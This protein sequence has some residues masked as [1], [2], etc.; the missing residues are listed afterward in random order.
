MVRGLL[1][2]AFLA[3]LLALVRPAA[4]SDEWRPNGAAIRFEEVK[5]IYVREHDDSWT[6]WIAGVPEFVNRDFL[7]RYATRFV[8]GSSATPAST[9][10]PTSPGA[11]GFTLK[12]EGAA[13]LPLTA[14]GRL[15]CRSSVVKN[16]IMPSCRGCP[17]RPA[18]FRVVIVGEGVQSLS[19]T[20]IAGYQVYRK[21]QVVHRVD[22]AEEYEGPPEVVFLGDGEEVTQRFRE[23]YELRVGAVGEWT[24]SC[25]PIDPLPA[26]RGFAVSGHNA[27]PVIWGEDVTALTT[28]PTGLLSC[29]TDW[30]PPHWTYHAYGPSFQWTMWG[31]DE[32]GE[33]VHYGYESP[34][35]RVLRDG[36]VVWLGEERPGEHVAFLPPYSVQVL[37]DGSWSVSCTPK[38]E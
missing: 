21:D 26:A 13:T 3:V 33:R 34:Y 16:A 24:V 37:S 2:A 35:Q 27:G 23:P 10:A 18:P 19:G 15:V 12:G 17:Y 30:T 8:D 5:A 38:D 31:Y 25:E 28:A 1:T 36:A 22:A 29:A 32:A 11:T 9:P 7:D 4:L 20:G 14:S 6:T